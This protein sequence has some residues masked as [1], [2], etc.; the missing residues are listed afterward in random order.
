MYRKNWN[1]KVSKHPDGQERINIIE[2]HTNPKICL[3]NVY[4]PSRG[5][6]IGETYH[7]T[8]DEVE[9]VLLKY[10]STHAVFICGDM[11]AS[12]KRH[13]E[14]D[15][16]KLFKQFV[17]RNDLHTSQ[18]G[19]PTFIHPNG[20]EKFEI[21][22]ILTNNIAKKQGRNTVV[23]TNDPL[24]TS[25]HTAVTL[26][27]TVGYEIIEKRK[28]PSQQKPNWNKCDTELQ[29]KP[30]ITRFSGSVDQT[31]DISGL[32]DITRYM[33]PRPPTN[34]LYPRSIVSY[35]EHIYYISYHIL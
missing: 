29:W 5:N 16:D 23:I 2:L 25:D 28:N 17:R 27:L 9:E 4:L 1:I 11:N 22:Y 31:R 18:E 6:N 30:V 13:P 12:L 33:F 21:D 7:S 14:N 34:G 20:K 3:I 32:M 26:K 24:N 10:I 8:L 35:Y 15:H 19:I